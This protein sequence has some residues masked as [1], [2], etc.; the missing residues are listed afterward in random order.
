MDSDLFFYSDPDHR[1]GLKRICICA[2]LTF[3]DSTVSLQDSIISLH[4]SSVSLHDSI[5]SRYGSIVSLQVLIFFAVKHGTKH[6]ETLKI[7][8]S[9]D[10]FFIVLL[11]FN[12]IQ[13]MP[14]LDLVYSW[15]SHKSQSACVCDSVPDP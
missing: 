6:D 3:Q 15:M 10:P 2:L 8:S 5:V 13:T 14:C 4:S 11:I 1:Q 12:Y 9:M 7:L